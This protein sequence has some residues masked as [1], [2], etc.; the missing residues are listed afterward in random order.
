MDE[1]N[2]PEMRPTFEE[3]SPNTP[4]YDIMVENEN[5]LYKHVKCDLVKSKF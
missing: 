4:S 5:L 2:V 3:E 1:N